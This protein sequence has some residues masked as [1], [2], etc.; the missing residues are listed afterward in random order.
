VPKAVLESVEDCPKYC[1]ECGR[2]G[3]CINSRRERGAVMRRYRCK[4]AR[5]WTTL[6]LMVDDGGSQRGRLQ[7]YLRKHYNAE[8]GRRLAIEGLRKD[9]DA[10]LARFAHSCA[11]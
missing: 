2:Q 4:C 10:A 3:L 8:I 5:R 11:S 6:E 1:P 9:V 7:R